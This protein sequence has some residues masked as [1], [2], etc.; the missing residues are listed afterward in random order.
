M[1]ARIFPG[2]RFAGRAGRNFFRFR[3]GRG[4]FWKPR[5]PSA[6]AHTAASIAVLPFVN[7]SR[8]ERMDPFIDGLAEEITVGLTALRICLWPVLT[9]PDSSRINPPLRPRNS[10]RSGGAL[11]FA[12]Q[13]CRPTATLCGFAP[14]LLNSI[15]APTSGR[16]AFDGNHTAS[17]FSIQEDI[18][19]KVVAQL[20]HCFAPFTACCLRNFSPAGTVP[21]RRRYT[22][23]VG[24]PA[25]I[26]TCL[27]KPEALWNGPRKRFRIQ[28]PFWPCW[29]M[30]TPQIFSWALTPCLT[31]L[32]VPCI[33]PNAQ[34]L[35]I[36]RQSVIEP[37]ALFIYLRHDPGNQFR[38]T[39]EQV[40]PLNPANPFMAVSGF[41]GPRKRW[42]EPYA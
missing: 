7:L 26:R 38:R 37:E 3:T 32:T 34:R 33:W 11:C 19:Q 12:R 28:R 8:D 14:P 17:L 4:V 13:W 31:P 5:P 21:L 39:I 36:N 22:T 25:W 10:H 16:S 20:K 18:T 41:P 27:T 6:G 35:D 29:P 9:R 15:T 24:W 1:R 40:L 30:S 23:S 2:R 42:T